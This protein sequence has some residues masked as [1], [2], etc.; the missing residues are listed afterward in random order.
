[1]YDPLLFQVFKSAGHLGE[2]AAGIGEIAPEFI[3]LSSP[4]VT[5]KV[6]GLLVSDEK[7]HSTSVPST[8]FC[9]KRLK[10]DILVASFRSFLDL[11]DLHAVE[12][13][14]F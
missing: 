10:I 2:N 1:M 4:V 7:R 8:E 14:D 12:T 3:V 6:P 11:A 13:G 5:A 9:D